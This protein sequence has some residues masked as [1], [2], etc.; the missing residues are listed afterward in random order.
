MQTLFDKF[1][2][3]L[4][5]NETLASLHYEELIDYHK[6]F[7]RALLTHSELAIA[8]KSRTTL[9]EVLN[10]A[11]MF[12]TKRD[13]SEEKLLEIVNSKLDLKSIKNIHSYTEFE[14]LEWDFT[15]EVYKCHVKLKFRP[16]NVSV[17]F[18][19]ADPKD[20]QI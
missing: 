4:A 16:K 15:N 5:D 18:W 14:L 6:K 11:I 9:D 12:Q 17:S 19:H 1:K 3:I 13:E 2:E 20:I 10:L 8:N 7:I